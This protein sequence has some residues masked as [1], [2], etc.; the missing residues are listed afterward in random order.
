M[1]DPHAVRKNPLPIQAH[2]SWHLSCLCDGAELLH[3]PDNI[4]LP[5]HSFGFVFQYPKELFQKSAVLVNEIDNVDVVEENKRAQDRRQAFVHDPYKNS[6]PQ[7]LK[8]VSLVDLLLN[9]G[10][11]NGYDLL[12]F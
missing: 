7:V 3:E 5:L 2:S 8:S 11:T 10:V 4:S 1:P 12:E 6:V 9:L